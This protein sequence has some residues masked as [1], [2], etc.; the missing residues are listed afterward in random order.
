MED[1]RG[2]TRLQFLDKPDPGSKLPTLSFVFQG[3]VKLW[4]EVHRVGWHI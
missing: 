1:I 4:I 3:T 2:S